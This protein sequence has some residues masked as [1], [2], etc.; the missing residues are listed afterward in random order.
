MAG[1]VYV[2]ART[3]AD[4]KEAVEGI[5]SVFMSRE[6][7]LVPI[8]EMPD[9]LRT[10]K[11]KSIDPGMWVRIKRPPK[12]AGDLAYVE[13]VHENGLEVELKIVPRED[14]GQNEDSNAPLSSSMLSGAAAKR[15][16]PGN[17]TASRPPARLFSESEARKRHSRFLTQIDNLSSKKFQY[18]SNTYVGG[19]LIKSFKVNTLQTED[20]NPTLEEVS[21][22]TVGQDEGADTLDLHKLA[23]TLKSSSS[24]S[25]LPGDAVEIFSGEQRGITGRAVA[26]RGDIVTIKVTEGV[27][28]GQTVEAPITDLRKR[29]S[30]GNHVK[31]IGGS[32]YLDEVGMVVKIVDT[33]VTLFSDSNHETITVFS[34]DLRAA[35]DAGSSKAGSKYDLHDL[36]QIE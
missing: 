30:E 33:R 8:A 35:T 20:V 18:H 4:V 27:L 14:Y 26:V 9:L 19:F 6:M 25:Y 7:V 1:F 11:S 16:R 31:V 36:V 21:K 2:E 17:T 28:A 10:R 32:K 3:K 29:F 5:I 34:K 12:Y 15:K 22:F 23:T 13:E 24:D